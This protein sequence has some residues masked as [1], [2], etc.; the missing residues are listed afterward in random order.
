MKGDRSLTGGRK[1]KN[2]YT[3]NRH[4]NVS[5]SY[6]LTVCTSPASTLS[7]Q[8][9]GTS[10]SSFQQTLCHTMSERVQ[11]DSRGAISLNTRAAEKITKT[12]YQSIW[13]LRPEVHHQCILPCNS[14][15]LYV[16]PKIKTPKLTTMTLHAHL[17]KYLSH[18]CQGAVCAICQTRQRILLINDR[19]KFWIVIWSFP[20]F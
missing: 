18:K 19:S 11:M 6:L 1:K 4:L 7:M 16:T 15:L 5:P 8:R 10:S 13:M 3:L 12:I 9:C 20:H 2:C 14:I 17:S